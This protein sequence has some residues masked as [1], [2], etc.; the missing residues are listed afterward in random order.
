MSVRV[1]A[2]IGGLGLVEARQTAAWTHNRAL[3]EGSGRRVESLS[4]A[5]VHHLLATVHAPLGSILAQWLVTAVG[6]LLNL[7]GKA[8]KGA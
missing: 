4:V 6:D 2:R 8:P 5:G 3:I 7:G 1:V